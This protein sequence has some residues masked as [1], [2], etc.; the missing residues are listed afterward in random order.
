[1]PDKNP[2]G[3]WSFRSALPLVIIFAAGPLV[4]G[5]SRLARTHGALWGIT[6][7]FSILW[8]LAMIGLAHWLFLQWARS[9]RFVEFIAGLAS[10]AA[11]IGLASAIIM[12]LM[13]GLRSLH[14]ADILWIS[15]VTGHLVQA[16]RAGLFKSRIERGCE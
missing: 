15:G 2:L 13:D 16:G 6:T 8:A 7:L 11:I 12:V 1:M 3:S 4:Y 9:N 5:A 10:F 14:G